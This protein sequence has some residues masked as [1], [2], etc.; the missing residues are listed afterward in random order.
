MMQSFGIEFSA[1]GEN[2]AHGQTGADEVMEDWMNSPGHKANIM[3]DIYNQIGVGAAK[4]DN[5]TYYFTQ[6]FIKSI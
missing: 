4:A 3:S 5:G 6:L 1:A 2:I